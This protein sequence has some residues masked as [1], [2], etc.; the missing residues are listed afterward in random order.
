MPFLTINTNAKPDGI[1]GRELVEDAS[2]LV[3]Q[4][5][6]KPVSYVVAAFNYNEDMAFGG[7]TE[8]KGAL[9]EMKSVGFAD[10]QKLVEILTDFVVKT[11]NA[12]RRFVNIE[13][14]DMPAS[15]VAVGGRLL[16]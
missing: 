9:I 15:T 4:T 10:T 7:S 3:A 16:G 1:S 12:E 8:N 2:A 5:L 14:T 11:T 6:E 13:L